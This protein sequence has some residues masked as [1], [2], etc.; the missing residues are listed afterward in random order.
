MIA[1]A[2][3]IVLKIEGAFMLKKSLAVLCMFFCGLSFAE[4]IQLM[5]TQSQ[6]IK[7][8]PKQTS[9][10]N[11]VR[12]AT[13]NK[14]ISL[15]SI[16]LT[17]QGLTNLVAREHPQ[18]SLDTELQMELPASVQ[19]GMN[20]VPVLDQ[21]KHGSCVTFATTSAMD[22]AFNLQ[23]GISQ[24]CQL[25]L[26]NYLER[27]G[28]Y[29]SGWEGSFGH[30]VLNQMSMFGVVG[31]EQQF[32]KGCGGLKEYPAV[33]SEIPT[34]M[35]T[36][37]EF[38]SLQQ[39]T[40]LDLTSAW[41]PILHVNEAFAYPVNTQ[42]VLNKVKAALH[43]GDRV[44]FGSLLVDPQE[45]IAGAVGKVHVTN[46]AWVLTPK[47]RYDAENSLY[48]AGH[49]MVI[50]GYDDNAVATDAEGGTHV[51]LL[52]LRNSWGES[53]GDKGN[54]YMSYDYFKELVIEA[55]RIRTQP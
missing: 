51:G 52:T 15:M 42:S 6:A 53:I 25:E 46:D 26:G 5:G 3:L 44:T 30:I 7:T 12:G 24:L 8:A 54:F 28:F 16:K 40:S 10:L 4:D 36:P 21:G 33:S 49:E 37:D 48:F 35:M 9:R 34:S 47:L 2:F 50:S 43:A 45:G 39:G 22:A 1:Y 18:A 32:S 11:A 41:Y 29:P 19:L 17:E 23:D 31:K 55:H 27:I 20:G 38:H 14:M 13:S